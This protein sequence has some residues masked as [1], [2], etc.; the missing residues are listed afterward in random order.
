MIRNTSLLSSPQC[1]TRSALERNFRAKA[2][3][4]KPKKTLVVV[5]QPPDLGSEESKFGNKANTT[6]GSASESPNPAIPA[7][8]CIAPPSAESDPAKSDPKIGPVQENDTIAKVS[9]IKKIPIIPP[10]FEALS[11]FVLHD[12]GR[13]IS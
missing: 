13:V 7:V 4:K 11:I 1:S 2:N 3:S 12:A 6:K 9:A 10:I 5:I 8:S